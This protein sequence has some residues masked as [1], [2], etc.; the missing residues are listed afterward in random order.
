MVHPYIHIHS[1]LH[2]YNIVQVQIL[3]EWRCRD[4]MHHAKNNGNKV[5]PLVASTINTSTI[6]CNPLPELYG[7]GGVTLV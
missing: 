7:G 6:M 5:I 3:N 1:F 4:G 2:L